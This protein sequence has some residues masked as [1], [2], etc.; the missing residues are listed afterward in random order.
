MLPLPPFHALL[1][2]IISI[3]DFL[4]SHLHAKDEFMVL[5]DGSLYK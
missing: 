1:R 2:V 4:F 3:I 5:V